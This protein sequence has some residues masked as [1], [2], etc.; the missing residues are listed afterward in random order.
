MKRSTRRHAAA[1][2]GLAV[3]ATA[4]PAL[5][6]NVDVA[7]QTI[8][9][10][11]Q[12]AV[13]D[14]SGG[15]LTAIDLGSGGQQP[16]RTVV[17]DSTFQNVTQG[18]DVSAKMNN[19]Y[20]H[21]GNPLAPDFGTKVPSSEVSLQ[22]GTSPLSALGLDLTVLPKVSVSGTLQSCPELDATTKSLLG[23]DS[24]GAVLDLTDTALTTL[25]SKLLLAD[26][27]AVTGTV[28]SALQEIQPTLTSLADLPAA[29]TGA[30]PGPFTN[31]DY[32]N[33]I[34]VGDTAGASGAPAATSLGIMTGTPGLSSALRDA[35]TAAVTT[36]IGSL[37]LTAANDTGSQTTVAAAIAMLSS[38]TTTAVAEV[39]TALSA[40]DAAKQ[41]ALLNTLTGAVAV[42][43]LGDIRSISG[44]YYA[45][46]VLKATPTTP[47][48]G[49]Y[50][51]TMTVTFVQE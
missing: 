7:L 44:R 28:D 26:N 11:R 27:Q 40:L 15:E 36:S 29:L 35:I 49:T 51:G 25:C 23:L 45:F 24:L 42:P 39:G 38:S 21:T 22:Y 9:G 20:L 13:Q 33:G 18:Y 41:S 17:T 48:P 30:Q 14:I 6:E 1:T 8:P 2:L 4:A 3:L 31:A 10:S 32:A 50:K 34:G 43:V 16:F 5:A 47:V 46:P 12:F 19:L 37:P